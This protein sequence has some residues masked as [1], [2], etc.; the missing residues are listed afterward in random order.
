MCWSRHQSLSPPLNG[1]SIPSEPFAIYTEKVPQRVELLHTWCLRHNQRQQCH[2]RPLPPSRLDHKAGNI[3]LF[4]SSWK[5]FVKLAACEP[6]GSTVAFYRHRVD[7]RVCVCVC[8]SFLCVKRRCSHDWQMAKLSSAC[9][10]GNCF[11]NSAYAFFYV[12]TAREHSA[13]RDGL[14]D[15]ACAMLFFC[16]VPSQWILELCGNW[17]RHH[18]IESWR[19]RRQGK[20]SEL[21][22]SCRTTLGKET[23]PPY[24]HI[25]HGASTRVSF[26]LVLLLQPTDPQPP[27]VPNRT[28]I[29]PTHSVSLVRRHARLFSTNADADNMGELSKTSSV[30]RH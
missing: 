8:E 15:V 9:S 1:L 4:I 12:E 13:L 5:T 21:S 30:T 23:S 18:S 28:H 16:L 19:T 10:I 26:A 27:I 17:L 25:I 14:G 11:H 2:W 3:L 7:G 22:V 20:R 24:H 6:R 29:S